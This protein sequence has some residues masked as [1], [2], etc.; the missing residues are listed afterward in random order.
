MSANFEHL[1][2]HSQHDGLKLGVVICTPKEKPPCGIIQFIHG[3]CEHKERYFHMCEYFAK[4]GYVSIIH[5]NRGHGESIKSADDLGYFY[6]NGFHG[7]INDVHQMSL[8]IKERY[9]NLPFFLFGFSM[10]SLIV[11]SYLKRYDNELD[12][13]FVCGC[14]ANPVLTPAVRK[15]IKY[16]IKV[17]GDHYRAEKITGLG[18]A[19][20]NAKFEN[21]SN[22]E[23]ICANP[24]IRE[25]H[26]QDPLCN[27]T[28][29]LNAYDTLMNLIEDVYSERD[30]Q[31]KNPEMP[32]YF[33]SGSDDPCMVSKSKFIEAIA[34]MQIIGYENISWRIY[35]GMRHEIMNEIECQ[36]VFDDMLKKIKLWTYA[37]KL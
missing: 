12:G 1:W 35:Q 7:M 13:L 31:L 5:D 14:V 30:W 6:E 19:F 23:W 25:Q 20:F 9:P 21:P 24:T 4:H 22:N 2:L 28:F 26:T 18:I 8:L 15:S 11:R 27:F 34:S 29:T 16:M 37:K 3:M 32:I 36:R 33:I 10:G 17:K